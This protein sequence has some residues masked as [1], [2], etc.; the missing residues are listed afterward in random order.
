M[1]P[2]PGL[3]F[4]IG[5]LTFPGVIVHETA[6]QL[7]CRWLRIAVLDV[8]YFRP[9]WQR[10][11][12]GYVIHEKPCTAWQSIVISMGPF[13]INTVLGAFIAAPGAVSM[14]QFDGHG[15]PL[16]ALL[17]YLGVAI[18][19]HAF[20]SPADAD[21]MWENAKQP[22]VPLWQRLIAGPLFGLTHL[23]HVG[24]ML[25]ADFWYGVAVAMAVPFLLVKLIA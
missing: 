24:K 14:I 10:K 13:L 9:D 21:A 15:D 8:V 7:M 19:M 6:H 25:W 1:I 5:I 18:A 3:G 20:P 16:D 17:V 22:G 23:A 2:I 11:T 12:L 4:L